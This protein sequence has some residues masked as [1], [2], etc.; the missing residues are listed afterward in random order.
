MIV[1]PQATV[2]EV[3]DPFCGF[4]LYRLVALKRALK[5][6]PDGGAFLRHEGW[7][8]SLELLAAV[9]PHLRSATQVDI[10]TD[11]SRRYRGSRF[12]AIATLWGLLK[13][14]RDPRLR[15]RAPAESQA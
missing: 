12:R 13:A 5:D 3:D 14:S 10:A 9:T 4:R 1:K 6:V 7:A 8:C 15:R 11:Y 2:T